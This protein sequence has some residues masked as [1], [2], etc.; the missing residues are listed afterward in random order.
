MIITMKL[1]V[2]MLAFSVFIFVIILKIDSVK[3]ATYVV[4][5]TADTNDGSCNS[6]CSLREAVVA[7]NTNV[8]ADIVNF[9]IPNSDPNYNLSGDFFQ[10]TTTSYLTLTDSA[11]VFIDG[12]SQSG[13][14]RNS[15]TFGNTLNTGLKIYLY[16]NNAAAGVFSLT[17]GNNH[18]AGLAI[19]S[20]RKVNVISL[21]ASSN[22]WFEGNYL[23]T[24]VSGS[25]ETGG[26]DIFMNSASN[27]N[28]FGT[29]GDGIGDSGE[30][31]LMM[32]STS[33]LVNV[34]LYIEGSNNVIAGNYLGVDKTTRICTT[35]VVAG[36]I[37][38]I[39]GGS[40]NNRV[41]SN[42]DSVSDSEETNV[43]GCVNNNPRGLIRIGVTTG[44]HNNLIQGNYI[45][46][47]TFGDNLA[48][49]LV[50]RGL[51]VFRDAASNN[52]LIKKNVIANSNRNGIQMLNTTPAGIGNTFSQNI[53]Y[54]NATLG[55]GLNNGNVTQ[56]LNDSGDVDS[57]N[58]DLMNYP[59]LNK[60]G[61]INSKVLVDFNLDFNVSEAPFTI[62]VFDNDSLDTTGYGQ[63]KYFIGSV[64]TSTIGSHVVF[65]IPIN[66]HVPT[67]ISK[68]T[69]TATN[70]SGSTSEFSTV[71]VDLIPK[72]IVSAA[73]INIP[74]NTGTQSVTA[75]ISA[76]GEFYT[77]TEMKLS[78]DLSFTGSS[79][80]PYSTTK[81]WNLESGSGSKTVYIKFRD[82]DGNETDV[83]NDSTVL[84]LSGPIGNIAINSDANYSVSRNVTLNLAATDTDSEVTSM[85][86]SEFED[87]TGATWESFAETKS[88]ELPVGTEIRL[89]M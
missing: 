22:N 78:N 34:Y 62:E 36:A 81:L 16:G 73:S 55:I 17:A 65:S 30:R 71:S 3:A 51:I 31:N 11:G 86:I 46:T 15:A 29:N 39:S 89:F 45:G 10:I 87:W 14:T 47:N 5:K 40:S 61:I 56:L 2:R 1:L 35:G 76:I 69:A 12:Y 48:N 43:I 4:T 49:G 79:W 33:S 77:I 80:E 25:V 24:N 50:G 13:A 75:V 68:I 44:S 85:M 6:D 28:I 60:V 23:G 59:V 72:S 42:M 9:A 41:G 53:L 83:Y 18:I 27:N 82:S 7:A 70:S 32:G 52:N 8:G 67:G 21:T 58:N 74:S 64:T 37:I 88:F 54:N 20:I 19:S 57:G 66:N 26:N 84:D 63:G 38:N